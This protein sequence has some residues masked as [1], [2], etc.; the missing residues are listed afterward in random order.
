MIDEGYKIIYPFKVKNK[1]NTFTFINDVEFYEFLENNDIDLYP[2]TYYKCINCGKKIHEIYESNNVD[3]SAWENGTVGKIHIGYG[4]IYDGN[5][6]E[7][8]ICDDCIDKLD[9]I[10]KLNFIKKINYEEKN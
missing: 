6:L 2:I 10:G 8:G 3:E 1:D 7:I 4:S 9:E 5:I